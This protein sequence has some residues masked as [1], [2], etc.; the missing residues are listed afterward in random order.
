MSPVLSIRRPVIL[1]LAAMLTLVAG[2]GL[3]ATLTHISGAIVAQGRI[4]VERDRQVVQHPDGGVVAEI[5][6]REGARVEAGQTLLRLDG[7]ALRS[8]LTIVEGQLSELTSRGARLAAERDGRTTLE[9]PADIL[10]LAKTSPKVTAQL[11]GQRRL[12]QARAATLA[13]ERDLLSRRIDQT[14]A[15]SNGIAAQS[16][17]LARQL[18]LVEQ[19]LASQQRL[20]EKGL[21]QAGA[22]L[23]LQREEARLE[24]QIGELEAE[25][26]R[27]RDQV[28]EIEIERSNLET[29][30]REDAAT[31]LRQIEPLVLELTERRRALIER[32]D[33]LEIRAPVAGIVLG[34]QVTTPQSVLR[35]AD[36]VLYVIPQ[37][38]PL[39]ITAR[40]APIHIDE[41]SPGQEAELVFP[42]FSARDT[43]HLLGRVTLI[44]PDALT[45]PHT[46]AT[47]Y[48][49]ELQ[50]AAGER[51]RLG[52][53]SLV[54]GMPVE[55]FLQTGRRTPLAYLIKPFADYFTRA[56]RES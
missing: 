11:D 27:T 1:G 6:V 53:R 10:T 38:R 18:D 7:A 34:L 46:G 40:I 25:L 52:A 30:R 48:A 56:F 17:A 13:E 5:L 26:A 39:V 37:D 12:F 31:E 42:A 54:P 50:L 49:A 32:I 55:V 14:I 23:A 44:A 2:F 43:P 35:A 3:W 20:L 51:A 4:E 28:T 21:T 41:V 29:R 8:E 15:Q 19:E 33:R 24:G 16:T 47:Y 9:F 45:D 22:V 36:P